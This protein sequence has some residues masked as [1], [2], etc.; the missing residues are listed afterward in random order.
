MM[1][2]SRRPAPWA[3]R[4]SRSPG[5]CS[6]TPRPKSRNSPN[7]RS[8]YDF[9]AAVRHS[10]VRADRRTRSRGHARPATLAPRRVRHQ[11]GK[12]ARQ[13]RDAVSQECLGHEVLG[14]A[15]QGLEGRGA[16]ADAG[17]D[18]REAGEERRCEVVPRSGVLLLLPGRHGLRQ[19]PLRVL[20]VLGPLIRELRAPGTP[21]RLHRGVDELVSRLDVARGGEPGLLGVR[22]RGNEC[23]DQRAHGNAERRPENHTDSL[24]LASFATWAS[25]SRCTSRATSRGG[26][27]RA[28]AAATTSSY[29]GYTRTPS[30][31]GCSSTFTRTDT[32]GPSATVTCR[33]SSV[34][35]S[36]LQR[37]TP[38]VVLCRNSAAVTASLASSG[39]TTSTRNPERP[40]F[41][42]TAQVCTSRAPAA[43][44]ACRSGSTY[45]GLIS[46]RSLASNVTR[47]ASAAASA[48]RIR[49]ALG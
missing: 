48:T 42:C 11:A 46:S 8:Q 32:C 19:R 6:G 12:P 34:A 5:S 33:R 18:D 16:V 23:G 22:D 35:R 1:T 40:F 45:S 7:P 20:Q 41:I 26:R 27:P 47:P 43:T 29:S 37:R 25:A 13:H 39:A 14:S 3:G 9:Q 36:A 30:A 28:L 44:S 38:A 21:E 15:D 4:P 17:R 24:D 31:P 10:R 2:S 49:R